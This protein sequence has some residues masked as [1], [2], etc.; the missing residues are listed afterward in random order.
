MTGRLVGAVLGFVALGGQAVAADASGAGAV[1]HEEAASGVYDAALFSG[2]DIGAQVNAAIAAMGPNGGIVMIPPGNYRFSTTI[3]CPTAGNQVVVIEGVPGY[4]GGPQSQFAGTLLQYTG[5]G[6]G[7]SDLGTARTQ[8]NHG[9]LLKDFALD[10]SNSRAGA[11]GIEFGAVALFRTENIVVKNFGGAGSVGIE[12]FNYG[13][14]WT[15]RY[16]IDA[17]IENCTSTIVFD[18]NRT[19]SGSFDHGELDIFV[20]QNGGDLITLKNGAELSDVLWHVS[21]NIS[22]ATTGIAIDGKSSFGGTLIW[23]VETTGRTTRFSVAAG[24]SASVFGNGFNPGGNEFSDSGDVQWQGQDGVL[25]KTRSGIETGA[26]SAA[27]K[28]VD[29]SGASLTLANN[30]SFYFQNG[31]SCTLVLDVTYP[32]TASTAAAI[33]GGAPPTCLRAST[34]SNLSNVAPLANS[35]TGALYFGA[36]NTGIAILSNL[37]FSSATNATVSGLRL[38]GTYQVLYR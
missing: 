38:K 24:G 17:D 1:Q 34:T 33:I 37:N 27:W 10:G 14:V 30:G 12:G 25:F 31:N 32:P 4:V 36:T 22:S 5:S 13:T 20:S 28:P 21:G 19:G 6:V 15:E 2:S 8:S 9:C 3:A 11:I 35:G 29:A 18:N 7:I 26:A 23:D 16:K